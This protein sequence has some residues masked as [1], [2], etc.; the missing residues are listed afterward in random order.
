MLLWPRA[1]GASAAL[2]EGLRAEGARVEEW[3]AYRTEAAAFDG[4][5]DRSRPLVQALV[6]VNGRLDAFQHGGAVVFGRGKLH[7]SGAGERF[8][9]LAQ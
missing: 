8:D 5:Q 4:L 1:A 7:Q 6:R 9:L 2:A 3:V